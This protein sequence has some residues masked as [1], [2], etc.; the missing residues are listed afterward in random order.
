MSTPDFD[1]LVVG[2][3]LTGIAFATLLQLQ[4]PAGR[5]PSIGIVEAGPAP[6]AAPPAELALRVVALSPASRAILERCQAWAGLPESRVGPYRRMVV[7]HHGGEPGGK[8]SITFDAADEGVAEL[9]YIVESDLVRSALWQRAASMPSIELLAG[10]PPVALETR[11]DDMTLRLA[12]GR[13][14]SARLVVGADGHA[15]WLRDALGVPVSEHG[16]GQHAVVAHIA[17][18]CSHGQ[19]AWQ[20]FMA[21]GPLALLPLPDGRCSIVWSCAESHAQALAAATEAGFNQVLTEASA[22]VLGGLRVTTR[23]Q[24][25]P[26]AAGHASQYTGLRFALIGDA[27]HRVHPLAGQGVNLGFLDA[28]VLAE[29]LADHRAATHADPGDPLALRRFERWRKGANLAA[30][31]GMDLLHKVFTSNTAGVSR[32]AG[33]GLGLVNSLSPVKHRLAG[34]AM[35]LRGD[36]P[37]VV[38]SDRT[39]N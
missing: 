17:S 34:Y 30:L 7:W 15:S 36:L 12:D 1:V 5:V 11:R 22:G 28:A 18:E 35:G 2:G 6:A 10:A 23:R 3:G 20:R 4:A 27:A 32:A 38:R 9:G 8:S 16:Y 19:T 31:G 37:R 33:A 39:M 29:V 25:F 14:L 24:S 26:L 13:N 21:D